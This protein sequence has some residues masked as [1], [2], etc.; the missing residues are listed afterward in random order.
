MRWR[1]GRALMVM[2]LLLTGAPLAARAEDGAPAHAS[3]ED[4]AA[5]V[6]IL[7]YARGRVFDAGV[8][9]ASTSYGVDCD[10]K[11]LGFAPSV[12]TSDN[13]QN[14]DSGFNFSIANPPL[15]NDGRTREFTLTL[16]GWNRSAKGGLYDV[17]KCTTKKQN[18]RWQFVS[19]RNSFAT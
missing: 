2:S 14:S 7:Q 4:C 16:V 8:P 11:A 13:Y 9:M 19:C 17:H 3:A 6:P 12:V 10:W 5:M 15:P 1:F 18:G